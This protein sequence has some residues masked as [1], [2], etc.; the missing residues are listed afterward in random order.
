MYFRKR[1]LIGIGTSGANIGTI[2][3]RGGTIITTIVRTH[4]VPKVGPSGAKAA[5]NGLNGRLSR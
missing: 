5:E 2:T 4:T 1:W 3:T